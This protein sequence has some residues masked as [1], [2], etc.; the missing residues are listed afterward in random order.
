MNV[1]ASTDRRGRDVAKQPKEDRCSR[2]RHAEGH[3]SQDRSLVRLSNPSF[4]SF[5][6]NGVAVW[7]VGVA[8]SSP[9]RT[10][11]RV[12]DDTLGNL[13]ST[14]LSRILARHLAS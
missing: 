14:A 9:L 5:L 8:K 4:G 6:A 13:N 1:V 7:L 3:R 12:A 2:L 11:V 10:F